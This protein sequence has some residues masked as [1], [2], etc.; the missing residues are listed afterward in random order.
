MLRQWLVG[1]KHVSVLP[2]TKNNTGSH[3]GD[4]SQLRNW[5]PNRDILGLHGGEFCD[6]IFSGFWRSVDSS[7]DAK[8]QKNDV[9]VGHRIILST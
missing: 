5:P 1:Q 6:V 7:A 8:T 9:I 4:F 3:P 2:S